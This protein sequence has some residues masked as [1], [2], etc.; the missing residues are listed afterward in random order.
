MSGR[1]RAAHA[2]LQRLADSRPSNARGIVLMLAATVL[3]TIMGA[4]ARYVSDR[5]H[6]FEVVF[7]RNAFGLVL[8]LPLVMSYGLRHFRTRHFGLHVARS[9][10]HV[11]EMLIYF[12]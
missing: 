2:L 3:F 12:V 1:L 7:F 10:G 9:A 11:S 4:A 6:P 8:L 5:I